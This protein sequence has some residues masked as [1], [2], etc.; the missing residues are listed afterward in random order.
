VCGPGGIPL[1]VDRSV[2]ARKTRRILDATRWIRS[3][4]PESAS[5]LAA[6]RLVRESVA[7]SLFLAIQEAIDLAAHQLADEGLAIPDRY[8]DL[9]TALAD[10]GTLEPSLAGEMASAAGLRNL[11]AHRY[12]DLD[13]ERLHQAAE[14]GVDHL[15]H[16]ADSMAAL[17]A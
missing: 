5:A 6:D 9:F 2:V 3:I 7:L 10:H 11:I 17:S 15:E 8:R 16:F 12:G 4:L 14:R 1:V 13:W